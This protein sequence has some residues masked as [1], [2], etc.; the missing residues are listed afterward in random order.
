MTNNTED[1]KK[2]LWVKNFEK[3]QKVDK[4]GR[5][6]LDGW[7]KGDNPAG[8][9]KRSM[10]EIQIIEENN[11]QNSESIRENSRTFE[12]FRPGKGKGKGK[13][14]DYVPNGTL[15]GKPDA[16]PEK[17]QKPEFEDLPETESETTVTMTGRNEAIP[18]DK[19]IEHLNAS[20]GKRFKA[21]NKNTQ[22]LIKARWKQGFSLKDFIAVIDTK[23][24]KWMT[25]PQMIDYL[26]PETLF[27]N[28]F[29]GYLNERNSKP[30]I[31]IVSECTKRNLDTIVRWANDENEE[32]CHE[33][34]TSVC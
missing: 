12:N 15:S 30:E 1:E 14:K 25:D 34:Q 4:P 17:N 9:A 16:E 31:R 29:E 8:Y 2:Y 19:I 22:R 6:L 7:E 26:R 18:Y 27:G 20:T 24:E 21:D 28:K 33:R 5:P 23:S 13:G 3:H 10:C 11:D 32:G